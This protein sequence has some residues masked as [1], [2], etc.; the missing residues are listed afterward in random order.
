MSQISKGAGHR[1]ETL[2]IGTHKRERRAEQQDI[3]RPFK[4]I[5]GVKGNAK[6]EGGSGHRAI[7]KNPARLLKNKN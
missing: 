7:T 1:Q 2:R 5:F 4:M 6:R 3:Q